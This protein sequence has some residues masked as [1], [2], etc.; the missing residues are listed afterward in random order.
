M[1]GSMPCTGLPITWTSPAL[2]RSNPEISPS[3]VDLP[4]PVGP[5][6][7]QNSPGAT[8]RLRSRNAVYAWP[9]GVRKRLV[10]FCNS[11]AD[12][13]RLDCSGM[14]I[15]VSFIVKSMDIELLSRM[16]FRH[17]FVRASSSVHSRAGCAY[18]LQTW[19]GY[20]MG[21]PLSSGCENS[22]VDLP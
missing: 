5:T 19:G 6:T 16:A 18:E 1:R 20:Q 10:T 21:T 14:V 13:S 22:V 8:L 4:H 17:Y 15:A 3:V 12:V 2:G 11:I 7:A 9:V